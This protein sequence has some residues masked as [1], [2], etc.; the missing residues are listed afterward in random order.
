MQQQG[1]ALD[2][3]LDADGTVLLG[4][5]RHKPEDSIANKIRVQTALSLVTE[6]FN[7]LRVQFKEQAV[8]DWN[9]KAAM[10]ALFSD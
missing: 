1:Y 8:D 4:G 5:T 3:A 10:R 6:H 9:G 2:A 7:E